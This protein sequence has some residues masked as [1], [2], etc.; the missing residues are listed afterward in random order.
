MMDWT[1]I[2]VALISSGAFLGMFLVAEKKTSAILDSVDKRAQTAI[3][4]AEKLAERYLALANEHQEQAATLRTQLS[5]REAELMN[6]I[7]MNSSLRHDLDDSHTL[8]A[9]SE[10][11]RCDVLKC[12]DRQPPFGTNADIIVTKLKERKRTRYGGEDGNQPNT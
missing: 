4:S 6:Q 3:S 11:R 8:Q 5:Q 10:M 12:P 2:V 1:Q 7:K 9:V